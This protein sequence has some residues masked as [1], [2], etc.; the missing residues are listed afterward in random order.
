MSL[1]GVRLKLRSHP[2][3]EWS[4][5]LQAGEKGQCRFLESEVQEEMERQGSSVGFVISKPCRGLTARCEGNG[6]RRSM[7]WHS[8]LGRSWVHLALCTSAIREYYPSLANC[9]VSLHDIRYRNVTTSVLW[10]SSQICEWR[11]SPPYSRR[12]PH[13]W[14]TSPHLSTSSPVHPLTFI[15]SDQIS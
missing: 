6:T 9:V 8:S 10:L 15:L 4:F 12:T 2:N 14:F 7:L 1:R 13:V 5:A 11:N 3:G